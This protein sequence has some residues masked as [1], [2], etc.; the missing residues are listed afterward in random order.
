MTKHE[1]ALSDL[2]AGIVAVYERGERVR[3]IATRLQLDRSTVSSV[4]DRR[5]CHGDRE[6]RPLP[7]MAQRSNY[8]RMAGR[9][10]R[11]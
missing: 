5:M 3:G 2:A 6:R 10:H 1:F 7:A 4:L 8:E 9:W 11:W